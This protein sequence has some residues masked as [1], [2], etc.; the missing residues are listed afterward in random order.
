MTIIH[1]VTLFNNQ[2]IRMLMDTYPSAITE[3]T[4]KSPKMYILSPH[5]P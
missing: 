1:G 2:D 3:V 5:S 4:G